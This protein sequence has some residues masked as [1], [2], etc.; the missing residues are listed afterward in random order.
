MDFNNEDAAALQQ[1]AAERARHRELVENQIA[2][3]AQRQAEKRIHDAYLE[4]LEERKRAAVQR[5]LGRISQ[6]SAPAAQTFYVE[7]KKFVNDYSFLKGFLYSYLGSFIEYLPPYTTITGWL[8]DSKKELVQVG[9]GPVSSRTTLCIVTLRG[10]TICGRI[11]S[12]RDN[13]SLLS[14]EDETSSQCD[15]VQ[16]MS[17]YLARNGLLG[18]V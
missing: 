4:T 13:K 8:L 15:W 11:S 18:D 16:L 7:R 2:Y 6:L 3:E 9:D 14:Y 1:A 10:E 5:F 17:L 12:Y